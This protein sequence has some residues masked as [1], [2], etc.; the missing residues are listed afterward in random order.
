MV[1][2]TVP[3]GLPMHQLGA[4]TSTFFKAP[5]PCS[6]SH[7]TLQSVASHITD[8]RMAYCRTSDR[9]CSVSHGPLQDVASLADSE[10][11]QAGKKSARIWTLSKGV[12]GGGGP[13][14]CA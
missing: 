8:R 14:G 11:S 6:L 13:Y 9:N 12:W 2:S 3:E 10:G 5:Q 7:S 1:T 4:L